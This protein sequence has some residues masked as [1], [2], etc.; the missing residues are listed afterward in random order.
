MTPINL[1]Y[2][3]LILSICLGIGL[4]FF[5]YIYPKRRLSSL[6]LVILLSLLPVVSIFRPGT[7]ESGDLSLHVIR[8]IS[9]YNMLFT[10]RTIPHWTP[11]FNAG[12]GDPHFLFSYFLPYFIGATLHAIGFTFLT[13]LKILL[14]G[15]YIFSGITMFR[16]IKEVVNE[17][18]GVVAAI[19]YLF[20]PYH[21]VD[22]HFRV[23]IAEN[24]SFL[25]LPLILMYTR[26]NIIHPNFTNILFGSLSY[27]L[28]ILSHQI[29][30]L[31]F[32]P[33]SFIY[34]L[35]I[36]RSSSIKSIRS[37][38]SYFIMLLLGF[39][40]SAFYWIPIIFEAKYTQ[41][42]LAKSVTVFPEITELLYSTWRYGFL[43]QGHNGELSF[44]IGY[45]QILI[46]IIGVVLLYL[47]VFKESLNKH[48]TFFL[49][50]FISSTILMLSIS[51]PLWTLV[52]FLKY[53]QYSY[54]LL[55]IVSLCTAV[56]AGIVSVKIKNGVLL[57][58]MCAGTIGYIMRNWGNRRNVPKIKSNEYFI[59]ELRARPDVGMYLEPST[60]VWADLNKSML[61]VRPAA[62]V[63]IVSGSG[64][65]LKSRKTAIKREYKIKIRNNSLIKENT[66]YFPGWKV[67]DNGKE[68]PIDFMNK[69]Y[70]GIILFHLEKGDHEISIEFKMTFDRVVGFLITIV[71]IIGILIL[72]IPTRASKKARSYLG[73]LLFSNYSNI[74]SAKRKRKALNS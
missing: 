39:A 55:E 42:S 56:I 59:N 73:S 32:I 12:Y 1:F 53:F 24:L 22:L 70:P 33:I 6:L 60:P 72:I 63:E 35:F 64:Q 29:I 13:S 8:T 14:A 38:L 47:K 11:E 43:F 20:A 3:S 50:L 10:E 15:S 65:I 46:V 27:S 68:I 2:Q 52:P 45:M 18:A 16:F 40:F 28:L 4:V 61:R 57:I 9:F 58:I 31:A 41:A 36:W 51:K 19:F 5:Q 66:L 44:I 25:F 49:L 67:T 54:R 17:R 21:L 37:F 7:Y 48:L 71:T 34:G 69:N 62:N 30:A 74:T 23:T 26:R